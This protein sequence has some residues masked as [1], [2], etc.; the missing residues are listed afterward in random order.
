MFVTDSSSSA[1]RED[2]DPQTMRDTSMPLELAWSAACH[3]RTCG[4]SSSISAQSV[5]SASGHQRPRPVRTGASRVPGTEWRRPGLEARG[6]R[7]QRNGC[8]VVL[9]VGGP[10][11]RDTLVPAKHQAG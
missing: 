8:A 10:D 4:S 1:D 9:C 11:K 6:T 5:P 3:P 7:R 2:A